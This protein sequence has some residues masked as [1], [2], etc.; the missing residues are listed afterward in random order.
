MNLSCHRTQKSFFIALSAIC[1]FAFPSYAEPEA[2]I[3]PNDNYNDSGVFE[4]TWN[5]DLTLSNL[6]KAEATGDIDSTDNDWYVFQLNEGE[7]VQIT[8]WQ[9]TGDL[10]PSLKLYVD[11]TASHEEGNSHG[12]PG[13]N[14]RIEE[15]IATVTGNHYLRI[16]RFNG[17][18]TYQLQFLK[19]LN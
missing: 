18:G 14:A 6:S 1:L 17:A 8:A 3:E 9:L 2:E 15:Y 4:V 7:R 13:T 10:V 11:P 19:T 5:A 16:A 12:G